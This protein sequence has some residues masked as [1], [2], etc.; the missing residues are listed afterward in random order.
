MA[1]SA[2]SAAIAGD[3]S[4]AARGR[5]I[6][7]PLTVVDLFCGAG[8]FSLGFHA[9]GYRIAAGIDLDEMAAAT[10]EQNFQELEIGDPPIVLGGPDGDMERLDLHRLRDKI[11][12]DVLISGPPCQPFSRVGRAKLN[13][14]ASKGKRQ[15][16]FLEDPR[17]GLLERF[18]EAVR[19]WQPAA[20]VMENVPGMQGSGDQDFAES[21]AVDLEVAGYRVGYAILNS[22]WYGVPQYRDRLFVLAL[23]ADLGGS[24]EFPPATHLARLPSGYAARGLG[25]GD[26]PF[27]FPMHESQADLTSATSQAVSVRAALDDL[28]K[29]TEHLEPEFRRMRGDFRNELK[30]DSEPRSSFAQLMR[31]W[32]GFP[33]PTTVDDHAIRL[34]RR[35]FETFR[36]MKPGDRYEE[37][38]AIAW[39]RVAEEWEHRHPGDPTPPR[40]E[41]VSDLIGGSEYADLVLSIVPPYRVDGFPDKWRKLLPEEPSWTIPAHLAKDSYSHIHYDSDQAR[42]ISVREAARLQSFPDAFRFV[43]NMGDCFRQIGNAVP[44]LLA[45]TIA[46]HLKPV[47]ETSLQK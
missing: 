25:W 36:R 34:T 47:L 5:P 20:A 9:A 2:E 17:R 41:K 4:L 7:R 32:P 1:S 35:D 30:Y 27:L 29:L 15:S 42:G 21:V 46:R 8:G 44:P 39:R 23:R 43:G 22:V 28:P 13:D 3:H 40:P 24:P 45:M 26:T 14:L 12:P 18:I 11:E 37:A 19:V 38:L 6:R 33:I 31:E 10:F 16:G